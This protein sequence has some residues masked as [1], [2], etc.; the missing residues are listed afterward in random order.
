MLIDVNAVA[1]IS[2]GS[3]GIGRGI[4]LELAK[5]GWDL[6]I[7]Y[8]SNQ[9]AAEQTAN[10]CRSCAQ[11]AGHMIRCERFKGD[12][13]KRKDREALLE[14]VKIKFGRLDLLVNNAGVAPR[15]RSDLLET[16]EESFDQDLD[17][18]VK[19]P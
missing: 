7:N 14:F 9:S 11:T 4:A 1:L 12:I 15:S 17:V 16:T 3:R 13:A 6:V 18:N 19:G 5:L 10:D 2:G 8:A